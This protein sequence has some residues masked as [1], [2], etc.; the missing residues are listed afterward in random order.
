MSYSENVIHEAIKGS[1]DYHA[2]MRSITQQGLR[3][4]A[5]YIP[6]NTDAMELHR[7][8]IK[9]TDKRCTIDIG[10]H[11]IFYA[12]ACGHFSPRMARTVW[13]YGQLQKV[14]QFLRDGKHRKDI[15]RDKRTQKLTKMV[16]IELPQFIGYN[17]YSADGMVALRN[18]LRE[19]VKK[20]YFSMK[21]DF[22][23]NSQFSDVEMFYSSCLRYLIRGDGIY[24]DRSK[25]VKT[26]L[27]RA[28]S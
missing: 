20:S 5:G 8:F 22:L 2:L 10:V 1:D 7:N 4:K 17:E 14:P 26:L 11:W 12:V 27:G 24:I 25:V 13:R 9:W 21:K 6:P 23:T 18:E 3:S 28:L 19:F 16:L 15:F